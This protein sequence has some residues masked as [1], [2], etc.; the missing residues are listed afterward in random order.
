MANDNVRLRFEEDETGWGVRLSDSH[1]QIANIP[2]SDRLNIDDVVEAHEQDGRLSAGRV[3]ARTFHGKTAISYP[4]PFMETYGKLFDAWR[5][6]GMKCEGLLGG[7][8]LIAH[9]KDSDPVK[10]AQAAGVAVTL[11]VPQPALEPFTAAE[12]S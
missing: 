11:Y 5:A 2:F 12:P 1:I 8:A 4:E 7:L 6:A 3:V 9:H 10:V